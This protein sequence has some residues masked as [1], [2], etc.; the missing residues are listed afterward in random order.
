MYLIMSVGGDG[1]FLETAMRVRETGIPVAGINTGRLGFLAN[2]PDDDIGKAMEMLCSGRYEV[3]SRSML[4][5]VSPEDLFGEAI[6]LALNEVT[7]QKS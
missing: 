3:I 5:I 6:P 7:I 4:E 2:I 1:T